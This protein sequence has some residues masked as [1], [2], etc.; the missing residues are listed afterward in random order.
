MASLSYSTSVSLWLCVE[1]LR[2]STLKESQIFNQKNQKYSKKRLALKRNNLTNENKMKTLLTISLFFAFFLGNN[3]FLNAQIVNIE[4]RRGSLVDTSGWFGY[5]GMRTNFVKN[6]KSVVNIGGDLRIEYLKGKSKIL[7]L[8]NYNLIRANKERFIDNGFQHFRFNHQIRKRIE[9][10]FF[11]QAQ[12]NNQVRI[13]F[14]GLVGNGLRYQLLNN[15]KGQIFMGLAYMFEYD[16]IKIISDVITKFRDHR[17]SSYISLSLQP[18]S[19]N[20]SIANTTYF[21]PVLNNFSDQ[22]LSSQ[23]SLNF[24]ISK[25][26]TFTSVFSITTDTRV[27]ENVPATYYSLKNG[28]RWSF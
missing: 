7:F 1:K 11:T 16:E 22:R 8:T 18:F 27:P 13:T 23:T 10:E 26:L 17:M 3:N 20:F 2:S 28:I 15:P 24:V 9:Y 25:R 21:Q 5:F 19:D 12:F 4:D 14:R 6:T